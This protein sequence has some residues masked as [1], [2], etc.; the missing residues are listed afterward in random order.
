VADTKSS[1]KPGHNVQALPGSR[2]V[3]AHDH[4]SSRDDSQ[5]AWVQEA[6][7]WI[8]RAQRAQLAID[9][10]LDQAE[11][12][13]TKYSPDDVLLTTKDLALLLSITQASVRRLFR[14]GKL[15][16]FQVDGDWRMSRRAYRKWVEERSG[17]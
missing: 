4:E 14:Q 16:G 7:D 9:D 8:A 17:G 6:K 12:N 2:S 10:I 1:R 15:L 5:D 3:Q 13:S 11:Q